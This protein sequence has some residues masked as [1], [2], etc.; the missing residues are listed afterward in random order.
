MN[1][2]KEKLLNKETISYLIF[3][4]LTTVIDFLIYLLCT[5]AFG[6][7]YLAANIVSWVIAVAFAYVTNKIFVFES[8]GYKLKKLLDEIS[9]FVSARVFS[10]VF[11][12]VFI[13]FCVVLFEMND[14]VAK[15]IA[16]VFVVIINYVLSKFYIFSKDENNKKTVFGWIKTNITYIV[17][18]I[19]PVI[20]LLV[21]YKLRKIFP[22]GDEMY[23]RSDC[24]H[25]YAPFHKEFF[26]KLKNGGSLSYSWNIG[27]GVN[28]SA[29]YAYYLA[30]P[31]N[32]FIAIFPEKYIVE[33]MNSYII[34]KAGL[35]SFGFSYYI[36]KK[37]N[38]KHIS[39]AAFAIFY[40]LSSYFAAFSWNVMWLDCLVLLPFIL[41]G[42]ERLVKENKCYLYC[43][44]LGLAII[45]N[46]YIAIMI[47]IFC[48]LYYFALIYAEDVK[49]TINYYTYKTLYFTIFSILAGGFGAVV[50][51]PAYYALKSTASG[52]FGF[53]DYLQNY[54]SILDMLSRSLMNVDASIFSAHDPNLYCT[55]AVFILIPLYFMCSN[56]SLKEKIAKGSLLGFMLFS[57]NTNIPNYIWHGFHFP[58]SLPCR[59]SFIYIFLIVAMSYEAFIN[60]KSFTNKQ[61]FGSFAG[62]TALILLIEEMY[63]GDDYDFK[64]IYYT[65]GFLLLYMIALM[66]YRSPN[67]KRGAIIFFIFVIT[68]SETYINLNNTGISTTSRSYYMDDNKD[69]NKV[70]KD[71]K[72]NDSVFYRVEKYD[73]RTKNDAAWSNYRGASTFSSTAIAA[74]SEFHG[75]IGLE[76][77]TNA[78]AYYGHTPLTEALFSIKYVL[79]TSYLDDTDFATLYS[80]S[81]N[82]YLYENTYTLPLG[83]MLPDGFEDEWDFENPDPFSVQNSFASTI[84]GNED[85]NMYTRLDVQ[86]DGNNAEVTTDEDLHLFIYVTTSL[87]SI[88]VETKD[89]EGNVLESKTYSDMTHS[90]TL[91]MGT[92]KADTTICVTSN[93]DEVSSLQLYAYSF[94][95]EVFI[96]TFD[97]LSSQPLKIETFEDTYVKGTINV[98]DDGEMFTSIPYDKGWSAY[99]DGNKVK[100]SSLEDA[101]LTIPLKSGEHVIELKYQPQGRTLGIALTILSIMGFA[102]AL[103]YDNQKRKR[104]KSKALDNIA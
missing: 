84:L 4:V 88:N 80:S 61:M 53:P 39:I 98:A 86:S 42:L 95:K 14:I 12:L 69:I 15:V 20:I 30:S 101:L 29:L 48:V 26:N 50:F 41:L 33:V 2:L 85:N 11:N 6:V 3:G 78:Y 18:F 45:S 31:I 90:H 23:L 24:Y 70:L 79:S 32:W 55:V 28:F 102:V 74:L 58:N 9:G 94:D 82:T 100:I 51:I 17:S 91:D 92:L 68:I 35:C 47:C 81:G 19:I 63:V 34:V 65:F 43:I 57:F 49:K 36:S 75:Q 60:I 46:Y 103:I 27:M 96:D 8:K 77:S 87:D 37:F 62:A 10:L 71:V 67:Y 21:I 76:E 93:D 99:V 25:Q 97:K 40:A 44:S 64:I 59:Q 54:F 83:F 66:L 56:I 5:K 38:T 7:N 22:F 1:D 13:Y 16:S 72:N 73:R 52:E 104:E 89:S